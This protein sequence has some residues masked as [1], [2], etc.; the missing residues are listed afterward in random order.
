MC[1][2]TLVWV[3]LAMEGCEQCQ[4]NE[5]CGL[6]EGLVTV[7]SETVIRESSLCNEPHDDPVGRH[8]EV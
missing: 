7:F 3:N 6:D 8:R 2:E 1:R 4:A 5:K